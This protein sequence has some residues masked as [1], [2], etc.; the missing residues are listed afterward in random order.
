MCIWTDVNDVRIFN[1]QS[2]FINIMADSQLWQN[3]AA[4]G[5]KR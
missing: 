3:R 1:L 5:L 4:I 2:F